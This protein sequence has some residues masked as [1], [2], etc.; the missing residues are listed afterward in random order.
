MYANCSMRHSADLRLFAFCCI[1]SAIV[2]SCFAVV[3]IALYL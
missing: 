3:L 2:L 1:V